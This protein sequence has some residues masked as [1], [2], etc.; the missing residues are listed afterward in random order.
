MPDYSVLVAVTRR[1]PYNETVL[2]QELGT[3]VVSQW[4]VARVR[5]ALHQ[6]VMSVLV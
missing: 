2:Q 1:L 6:D 4:R 3:T 5:Q